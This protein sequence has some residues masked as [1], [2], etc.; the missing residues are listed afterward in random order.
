L[1][2][3]WACLQHFWFG[4]AFVANGGNYGSLGPANGMS[5]K[6]QLLDAIFDVPNLFV[7]CTGF[8]NYDHN[9]CFRLLKLK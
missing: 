6:A 1:C 8:H 7:G 3:T 9:G 4:D 5:F 2:D